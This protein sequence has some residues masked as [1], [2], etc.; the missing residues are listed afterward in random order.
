MTAEA[1][2]LLR[3]TPQREDNDCACAA[4]ATYFGLSYEDVLRAVTLIDGRRGKGG[5]YLPQIQAIA[6]GFGKTLRAH[7]KFNIEED[8]GLL[9]VLVAGD[10][11]IVVLKRGLIFDS[12]LAVWEA[13]LY[14]VSR[15]ATATTLLTLEGT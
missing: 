11:H 13:D 6:R 2:P 10:A 12:N 15:K 7:R 5:L 8:E 14:L 9:R 1:V 3:L 4:M